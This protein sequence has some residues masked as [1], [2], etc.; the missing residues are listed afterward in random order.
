MLF[1]TRETVAVET[2]ARF[3]TSSRFIEISRPAYSN[4][5]IFGAICKQTGAVRAGVSLFNRRQVESRAGG[6]T[7]FGGKT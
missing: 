6:L 7:R 3:A 5:T 2:L 4:Y 1:N